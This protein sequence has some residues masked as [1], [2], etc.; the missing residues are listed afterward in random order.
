M[1]RIR[2]GIYS[3]KTNLPFRAGR[4]AIEGAQ[5]QLLEEEPT[6]CFLFF[7][8][9]YAT[10]ELTQGI[11]TQISPEIVVGCS[12]AGEIASGYRRESVVAFLI[13]S[14]Y[15]QFGMASEKNVNL[16]KG[17]AAIYQAFY[18]RAM[19]DLQTKTQL[20]AQSNE[21][22][23]QIS[24]KDRKP[25]F[26]IIFL[27][28]TDIELEPKANE[29][30]GQLRNYLGDT[31]LVGGT[32]GDD[33]NYEKGFAICKGEF[34]EDET[35]LVLGYSDLE[36]SMGQEHG[37]HPTKKFKATKVDKNILFELNNRSA[38]KVY[39]KE[40]KVPPLEIA[41]LRD[42]VPAHH[43]LAIMDNNTE[44][45]QYLF[46]TSRGKTA[47]DLIVSQIVPENST[48]FL[49]EV[50]PQKAEHASLLATQAARN[51]GRIRDP[52]AGLLFS[53]V[54]RSVFYQERA[55]E[56]IKEVKNHFKFTDIAGAYLYGTI[57]GRSNW[58]SEG[59]S[60]VLLFG[61][62]LR[63]ERKKRL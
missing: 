16:A 28:G 57:C 37:Y 17:S 27:P 9:R 44:T 35:V 59:T 60:S 50:E 46:P 56:E 30:L 23:P 43:P 8:E 63:Q 41:D 19:L 14:D 15:L 25:D 34:L 13:A 20:A 12:T 55:L 10:P 36:F 4:L 45:L 49:G 21:G 48:L 31:P 42:E 51:Q 52:R 53:C 18:E 7:S 33:C 2:C 32:I 39:F 6:I 24:Q 22:S 38:S 3:A 58:V 29:V 1:D 40:I 61:N 62:D 11:F 54:G 47:S 26:G 5:F